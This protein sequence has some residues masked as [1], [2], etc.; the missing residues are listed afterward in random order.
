MNRILTVTGVCLVCLMIVVSAAACGEQSVQADASDLTAGHRAELVTLGG[1]RL[2]ADGE[3]QVTF[4]A[5]A[6]TLKVIAEVT[7]TATALECTLS[8]F[9]GE[10]D[11][12]RWAAVPLTPHSAPVSGGT[13]FTLRSPSLES[14]TYRLTYSGRGQL[15]SLGVGVNY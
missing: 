10:G 11:A 5:D 4:R 3:Q 2:D 6:G 7:G 14:G 13:M 8:R 15:E 12:A 1:A 9:V